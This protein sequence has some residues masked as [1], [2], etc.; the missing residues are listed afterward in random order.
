MYYVHCNDSKNVIKMMEK[1]NPGNEGSDTHYS[2]NAL[3][4]HALGGGRSVQD[5]R[6]H[7]TSS[8]G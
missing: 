3:S 2:E 5:R 1:I 4:P 6:V 8:G 7:R